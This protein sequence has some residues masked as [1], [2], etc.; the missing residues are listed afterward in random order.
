MKQI[1]TY[2]GLYSIDR[3]LGVYSHLSNKYLKPVKQS[4]GY[5]TYNLYKD[6]KPKMFTAH[7]LLM[8]SFVPNPNNYPC[9]NHIDSDKENNSLGNLEWCTYS[10]NI[11]HGYDSGRVSWN[12]GKKWPEMS[13]IKS[14][15]ANPNA[16]SV[17]D[18]KTGKVYSTI[19]EASN[20]MGLPV[21]TVFS[22]LSRGSNNNTL[23]YC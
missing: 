9:V 13:R 21:G 8:T 19:V 14:G 22:R 18:F 11:K 4:N 20:D 2:E 23:E 12:K 3:V 10:H 7:R 1:P 17:R 6:G 5:L 15:G 16:R